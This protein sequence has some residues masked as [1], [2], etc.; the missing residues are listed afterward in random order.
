MPSRSAKSPRGSSRRARDH[1]EM[2]A[3]RRRIA[4]HPLGARDAASRSRTSVQT[5]PLTISTGPARQQRQRGRDAAGRLER[6]GLDATTRCRRR[7]RAPSPSAATSC[8][9]RCAALITMSVQ[10]ARAS[11]SICQTMSGL[12]PASSSGFGVASVSGRIRSPRPAARIIAPSFIARKRVADGDARAAL[13]LV[14]Q[15][16]Q[17]MQRAVAR[18]GAAQIG[19]HARHV[20]E[21]RRACRRDAR[22]A[23]RCRAP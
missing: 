3:R 12:P 7:T 18:A 9:R 14:E 8:R 1:D 2:R 20:V 15:R 13:E 10:P 19:H 21:I 4:R 17:R 22:G 11:A 16:E 23:R 5:S 6:L